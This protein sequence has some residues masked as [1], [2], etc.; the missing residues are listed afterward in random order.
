MQRFLFPADGRQ[1]DRTHGTPPDLICHILSV[2]ASAAIVWLRSA[3]THVQV[4]SLAS[5]SSPTSA[6]CQHATTRTL[7]TSPLTV[8]SRITYYAAVL[9]GRIARLAHA[10]VRPSVCPSVSILAQKVQKTQS[11][12]A[13]FSLGEYNRW[14]PMF[15]SNGQRSRPTGRQECT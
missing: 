7:M 15:S 5:S 4:S 13:C 9:V 10:S 6:T 12:G 11:F 1:F 3:S 14:A 2:C 8:I